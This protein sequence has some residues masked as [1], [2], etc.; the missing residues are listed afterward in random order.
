MRRITPAL[1]LATA[2]LLLGP[3]A[4]AAQRRGGRTIRIAPRAGLPDV[5]GGFS[6]CRLMYTSTRR[7]GSG[8]GW[9]TDYPEAER[10][11]LIRIAELTAARPSHWSD[12]EPGYAIVSAADPNLYECPFIM[13][14]DVGELGFSNAEIV[15]MRDYLA[16]GGF[17][18]ADDF[19]GSAG[20]D[21]FAAEIARLLPGYPMEEITPEHPL[22]SALYVVPKVPQIPSIQYWS[23]SGG[24]TSELGRD[25]QRPSMWT[26]SD[27]LGR[28]LV[29]ITHNTDISD[30]WER[31]AYDDRYFYLFSPEAYAL[32][33]NILLWTMT[34]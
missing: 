31:E 8:N 23:S 5:E 2:A 4:G 21:H 16:K 9:S 24:D 15:T 22:F 32:A 20:W 28:I 33:C 1:V 19:W 3:A 25:S 14:T 18:W 6:F 10:N 12:G 11:L 26:V 7:D 13:A 29:V 27:E 17:F 30:G 34:H